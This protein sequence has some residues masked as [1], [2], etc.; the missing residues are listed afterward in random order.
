MSKIKQHGIQSTYQKS[1]LKRMWEHK[2]LYLMILPN[3]ESL[4]SLNIM[5]KMIGKGRARMSFIPLIT[6]V[7]IMICTHLESVKNLWK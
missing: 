6:S 7:F 2:V 3:L 5:A 4:I 1:L